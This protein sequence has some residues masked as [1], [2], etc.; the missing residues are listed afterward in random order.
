[1]DVGAYTSVVVGYF[2]D[3]P[4]NDANQTPTHLHLINAGTK[5][6]NV[7]SY[8]DV[9]VSDLD[10]VKTTVSSI[11]S[12]IRSL[13]NLNE[14]TIADSDTISVVSAESQ[15]V[16]GTNY[17]VTIAFGMHENVIIQ[18]FIDLPVNDADHTPS[19]LQLVDLGTST[20]LVDTPAT[21]DTTAVIVNEGESTATSTI[22]TTMQWLIVGTVI[23]FIMCLSAVF[24]A[25][26]MQRKN[27]KTPRGNELYA[28]LNNDVIDETL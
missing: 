17:R 9:S 10:V 13:L 15:V 6:T 1:M 12:D 20:V 8:T 16:A 3:L 21:M 4:V 23:A 11:D 2:I 24:I 5:R 28:Q 22:S 7:G 26:C 18:Y 14:L 27:S 25:L 19:N